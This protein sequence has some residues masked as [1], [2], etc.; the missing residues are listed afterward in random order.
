MGRKGF[1]VQQPQQSDDIFEPEDAADVLQ[2]PPSE[3]D[4]PQN[5]PFDA[6]PANHPIH[7]L[8]RRIWEGETQFDAFHAVRPDGIHLFVDVNRFVGVEKV[9]RS[10]DPLKPW[11]KIQ[12]GMLVTTPELGR[13]SDW[14]AKASALFGKALLGYDGSHSL[15]LKNLLLFRTRASV[16]ACNSDYCAGFSDMLDAETDPGNVHTPFPIDKDDLKKRYIG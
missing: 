14:L 6:L 2:L 3:E 11:P 7:Q 13:M 16:N 10:S 15:F 5:V 1:T 9:S 12:T 8:A 4:A